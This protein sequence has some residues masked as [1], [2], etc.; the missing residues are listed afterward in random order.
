M[1]ESK[2][3]PTFKYR[4]T[5]SCKF[6]TNTTHFSPII[7]TSASQQDSILLKMHTPQNEKPTVAPRVAGSNPVAH[8]NQF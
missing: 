7:L 1:R 8:P 5:P 3:N 6:C 4:A 2:F